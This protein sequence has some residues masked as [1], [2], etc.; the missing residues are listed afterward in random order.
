MSHELLNQAL[1]RRHDALDP[2]PDARKKHEP[3]IP[4]VA[5]MPNAALIRVTLLDL[6]PAPGASSRCPCR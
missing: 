4:G 1:I 2:S 3:A 5:A 6:D